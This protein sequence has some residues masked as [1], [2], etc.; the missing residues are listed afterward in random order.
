MR[1]TGAR[2]ESFY[3]TLLDGRRPNNLVHLPVEP[4]ILGDFP[5]LAA[6]KPA[7]DRLK[8]CVV[9]IIFKQIII[10]VIGL[11]KQLQARVFLLVEHFSTIW[12]FVFE[13]S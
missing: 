11:P 7:K 12:H 1:L 3:K 6:C 4:S 5:R 2:A 13:Q 8:I 10:T 9:C